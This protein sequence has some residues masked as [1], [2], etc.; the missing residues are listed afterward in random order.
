LV[1]DDFDI[2]S[3][4]KV[5][6]YPSLS[7]NLFDEFDNWIAV[8]DQNEWYVDSRFVWDIEYKPKHL[9]LRN[10]PRKIALDVKIE[11]NVVLFK[12][13]LF[14]NGYKIEATENDLFLG[15]KS[16]IQMRGGGVVFSPS[17]MKATI[18]PVAFAL[19]TGKPP[20]SRFPYRYSSI[21]TAR[22]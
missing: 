9:I 14:F 18:P 10:A 20:F 1:V 13:Q 6:E 12:G 22:R 5:G 7:V 19:N 11:N 21:N 2:I 15:E 4:E 17:S 3:V 16:Q 8:I